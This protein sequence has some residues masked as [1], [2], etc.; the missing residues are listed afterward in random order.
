MHVQAQ[1][2]II[3]IW[4]NVVSAM[5]FLISQHVSYDEAVML[6]AVEKLK[7]Y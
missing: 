4:A 6:A 5:D 2:V 1:C 3:I 7:M